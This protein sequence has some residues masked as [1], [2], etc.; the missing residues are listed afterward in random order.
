MTVPG[1]GGTPPPP[2][3]YQPPGLPDVSAGSVNIFRGRLVIVFGP[4]GTVSGVFVYT[5]GTTPGP[6]NPPIISLTESA[7]DLFGNPVNGGVVVGTATHPQ[8]QLQSVGGIG[9]LTFLLNNAGY[10]DAFIDGGFASGIGV[11]SIQGPAS[12]VAANDDFISHVISAADGVAGHFANEEWAYTD[13]A[14]AFHTYAFVDGTGFNAVAVSQLTAA[15]PNVAPTPAAPAF[16]ETWHDLRPLLN[17]FVGTI[18]GRYPPQ[19]RKTADGTIEVEGYIQLPAAYNGVTVAN[20]PPPY[21]PGS[22][23]GWKGECWAETNVAPVGTPNCQVDAAGNL[24]LHNLPGGL[25]GTIVGIHMRYPLNNT[26]TIN[27]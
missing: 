11:I 26:G 19:Y 22:N 21:R 27:V 16:G 20:L 12:T 25:V 17:A 18:A 1:L 5:P 6:G 13:T 15:D 14:G 10:S 4:A 24:Q 2:P 7:A 23:S 8:V 3:G 9:K